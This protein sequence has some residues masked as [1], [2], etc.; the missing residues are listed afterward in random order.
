MATQEPPPQ[1][2]GAASAP[3]VLRAEQVEALLQLLQ[4]YRQY[5]LAQEPPT[6]ERN[7]RLRL[8]QALQGKLHAL[9]PPPGGELWLTLSPEERARLRQVLQT[10]HRQPALRERCA[11]QLAALAG[12]VGGSAAPE[13]S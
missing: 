4:G 5:V 8:A 3:L 6:T 1:G 13:R 2:A 11:R 7:V 10:V 9:Q 12:L